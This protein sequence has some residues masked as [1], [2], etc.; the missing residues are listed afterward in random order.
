MYN[1]YIYYTFIFYVTHTQFPPKECAQPRW[2][3]DSA[4][5]PGDFAAAAPH[6]ARTCGRFAW[7]FATGNLGIIYGA[8]Y[9]DS[10]D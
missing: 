4:P 6:A 8:L 2:P 10:G 7:N 9:N 5:L 3:K 1:I